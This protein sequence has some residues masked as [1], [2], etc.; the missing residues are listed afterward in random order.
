[1]QRFL[2]LLAQISSD[3]PLSSRQQRCRRCCNIAVAPA[4]NR[5]VPP[6][7]DAGVLRQVSNRYA[8]GNPTSQGPAASDSHPPP[9]LQAAAGLATSRALQRLA[10]ISGITRYKNEEQV[11]PSCLQILGGNRLSTFQLM[12]RGG[13]ISPLPHS[14]VQTHSPPPARD[15]AASGMGARRG[16][17]AG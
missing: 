15:V 2:D 17:A 10:T 11:Y 5:S 1:M 12:P 16:F 3:F 13:D 4:Y 6:H 9:F 14:P 7:P 8:H